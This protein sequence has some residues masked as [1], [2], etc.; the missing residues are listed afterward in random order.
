M[1]D[2]VRITLQTLEV[3]RVLLMQPATENYGLRVSQRCGLPTGSVYPILARLEAAEWITSEWEDIDESVE[4]RRRRRLYRLTPDG[5]DHARAA[6]LDAQ[7]KL[8][9][10]QSTG[11]W[12]PAPGLA[13]G[14]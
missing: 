2:K 12:N 5:A 4:G 14:H 9:S 3:L 6:L 8:G 10:S 11:A 1:A 7:R 13:W